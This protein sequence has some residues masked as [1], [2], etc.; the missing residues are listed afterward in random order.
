MDLLGMAEP[1]FESLDELERY[2]AGVGATQKAPVEEFSG[3]YADEAGIVE[4]K[5]RKSQPSKFARGL[6][7]TILT[8]PL[9]DKQELDRIIAHYRRAYGGCTAGEAVLRALRTNTP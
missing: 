5:E 6:R 4:R 1:K 2:R 7:D 9:E 3:A 8:L